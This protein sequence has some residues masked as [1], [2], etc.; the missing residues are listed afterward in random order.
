MSAAQA[1]VP[2]T[3]PSIERA[4]RLLALRQHPGWL[5]LIRLSSELVEDA[6]EACS[7]YPGWDAQMIVILKCR[8]QAAREHHSALFTGKV[9]AAIDSG[10]AEARQLES[11]LPAKTAEQ[12][13]ETGDLVRQKVLENFENQD[14]RISGTY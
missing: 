10:I 14:Q 7:G 1:F 5:E 11:V 2:E 8:M 12:A 9:Q 3:T 4:N 6:V 13:L